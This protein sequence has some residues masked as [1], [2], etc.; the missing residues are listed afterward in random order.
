[1][2]TQMLPTRDQRAHEVVETIIRRSL[3]SPAPKNILVSAHENHS[4]EPAIYIYVTMPEERNIPDV[5]TQNHLS[6]EIISALK[7]ADDER[8]PYL[9]FGPRSDGRHSA[10]T[11]END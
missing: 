3:H 4:G 5:V 8:F 1:M 2:T 11:G 10:R 9:S 6:S 7:Q